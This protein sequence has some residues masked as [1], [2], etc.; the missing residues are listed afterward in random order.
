MDLL[1]KAQSLEEKVVKF[2]AL[3]ETDGCA[4]LL[5]REGESA[6]RIEEIHNPLQR[7]FERYPRAV[8]M[9]LRMIEQL[10]G[11]KVARREL[12]GGRTGQVRVVFEVA[13]ECHG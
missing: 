12:A 13:A 6:W 7:L 2:V 4:V 1:G 11:A 5:H 8:A 10:L 3:R 9:E